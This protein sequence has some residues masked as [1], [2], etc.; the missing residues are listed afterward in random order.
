MTL[1]EVNKHSLASNREFERVVPV[2]PVVCE[3]A[4]LD[5]VGRV[6]RRYLADAPRVRL[7]NLREIH[8]H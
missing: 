8:W 5:T 6:H 3:E 4:R 1:L 2:G 7:H